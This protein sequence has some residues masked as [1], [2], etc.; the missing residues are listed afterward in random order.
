MG[1]EP[2][3]TQ[4]WLQRI[5]AKPDQVQNAESKKATEQMACISDYLWLLHPRLCLHTL[6]LN[7]STQSGMIA[8]GLVCIWLSEGGNGLV[9]RIAVA[10]VAADLCRVTRT[11]MR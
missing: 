4:S 6:F 1:S 2:Q 3:P 8:F 9:E 11:S 10:Q 5:N 7:C